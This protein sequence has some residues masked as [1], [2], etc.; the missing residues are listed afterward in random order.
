MASP[1]GEISLNEN[2]AD[3][4]AAQVP[5]CCIRMFS[6]KRYRA[7]NDKAFPILRPGKGTIGMFLKSAMQ[8]SNIKD[9]NLILRVFVRCI[10]GIKLKEKKKSMNLLKRLK[11]LKM[12]IFTKL[13]RYQITNLNC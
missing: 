6:R 5:E 1:E 2:L 3:Q 8:A 7:A 10:V 4:R 9:K 13:R 12:N 11:Y